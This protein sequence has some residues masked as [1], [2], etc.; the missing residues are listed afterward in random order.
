MNTFKLMFSNIICWSCESSLVA[1][2]VDVFCHVA[3]RNHTYVQTY[4]HIYIVYMYMYMPEQQLNW[5]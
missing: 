1:M 4:V 5:V 3:T 2:W